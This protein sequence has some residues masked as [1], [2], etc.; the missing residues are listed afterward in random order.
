MNALERH[1]E[2]THRVLIG[3]AWLQVAV[4]FIIG[5]SIEAS[6]AWLSGAALVA[7]ATTTGVRAAAPGSSVS[8]VT[9]AIALM[10]QISWLFARQALSAC[11]TLPPTICYRRR[12]FQ[13]A[14]I[15]AGCWF[16]RRSSS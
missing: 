8:R 2:L 13:A 14:A 1:R 4:I 9:M 16:M 10:A 6:W 15:S 11:I 12:C 7:A 3:L 5:W